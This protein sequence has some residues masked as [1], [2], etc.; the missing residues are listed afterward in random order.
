MYE[1]KQRILWSIIASYNLVLLT[2]FW[3]I[4]DQDFHPFCSKAHVFKMGFS[5]DTEKN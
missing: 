1:G 5:K 2:Y 4:L 3:W